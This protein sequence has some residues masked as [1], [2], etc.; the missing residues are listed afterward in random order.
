MY[1][2]TNQWLRTLTKDTRTENET[3]ATPN[4]A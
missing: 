3:E 4:M 1:G 2:D